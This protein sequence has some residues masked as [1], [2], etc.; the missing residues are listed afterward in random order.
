MR[1]RYCNKSISLL[2]RMNDASFCTD[3]HRQA[4]GEEQQLALQ[5]LTDTP[6]PMQRTQRVA[7]ATP[8]TP[9]MAQA[10]AIMTLTGEHYP[11]GPYP[12]PGPRIGIPAAPVTGGSIVLFRDREHSF[13]PAFQSPA[14]QFHIPVQPSANRLPKA[15]IAGPSSSLRVALPRSF[16]V[17]SRRAQGLTA[18]PHLKSIPAPSAAVA[19]SGW[20][21]RSGMTLPV[22]VSVVRISRP[23][24]HRPRQLRSYS[25][26]GRIVLGAA[27]ASCGRTALARQQHEDTFGVPAA[28]ICYPVASGLAVTLASALPEQ[29]VDEKLWTALES[30]PL[31]SLADSAQYSK[32]TPVRPLAAAPSERMFIQAAE[33]KP[34]P[35]TAASAAAFAPVALSPARTLRPVAPPEPRGGATSQRRIA[36]L[37]ATQPV[38]IVPARMGGKTDRNIAAE[39]TVMHVA[40]PRSAA[41]QTGASWNS[42][43]ATAGSMPAVPAQAIRPGA[44]ALPSAVI[45]DVAAPPPAGQAKGP[46]AGGQVAL[47]LAIQESRPTT[48]LRTL[49]DGLM[50][51]GA[52]PFK[53]RPDPAAGDRPIYRPDSLQNVLRLRLPR[54]APKRISR[55]GTAECVPVAPPANVVLSWPLPR[56]CLGR[57]RRR[58]RSP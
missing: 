53:L 30:R 42:D 24:P 27:G 6:H 54:H 38:R 18:V 51:S 17:Q 29:F 58:D 9:V 13:R 4:F 52:V 33:Y 50:V 14:R 55:Y 20:S 31:E 10:D 47:P 46:G 2:R 22:D 40:A 1:C 7:V 45:V 16:A 21:K 25:R 26:P 23:V 56:F 43:W 44:P 34:K 15:A 49:G 36:R 48:R 57:E 11:D 3:A 5:R 37:L 12:I 35:A 32:V 41:G 8:P 28:K 39:T 19:L